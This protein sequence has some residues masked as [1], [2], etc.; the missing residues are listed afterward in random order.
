MNHF[1]YQ[2]KRVKLKELSELWKLPIAMICAIFYRIKHNDLWIICEDPNEARDNGYWFFKYLRKEHP[3]QDCVYAISSKSPD[4]N[5]IR[6]LGNWVEFG[7]LKH[8]ILYLA[9]TKKISSQKA[10]NPNAAIFY[11]LEV[12]GFLKDNRIFLQHG[13]IINDLKWLYYDVTKMHRFICGAYP[14]YEFIRNNFGYPLENVVYTGICRFDGLHDNIS[15]DTRIILIMP[16][17]REWIADEDSRLLQYEGT[18][19]IA[20]TNYFINW[21]SFLKDQ[22]LERIA[23]QYNCRFIFFPHRNMQK[24]MDL[25]PRSTYYLEVADARQYDVQN[26]M[27]KA[28]L[29]ITDYSS[30]FM[31]ML[32][33]KKPVIFYQFDYDRFRMG[34]YGEGYFSYTQNPF[35]KSYI[36]KKDVLV[37]LEQKISE[38]FAVSNEYLLAHKEYF[39]L[40]DNSNCKRVY[41]VVKES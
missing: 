17:W 40:Y 38:G 32:Y 6:E 16:T 2:L 29:M 7:S 19:D 35:A 11:F 4:I 10:G 39:R 21:I 26:L 15:D 31:D 12:Y 30:V 36:T 28:S 3:E 5:K 33:M 14:E 27:K 23:N 18:K 9:S 25:F 8:W 34:Q 13:V 24:Y 37:A 1:L 20:K 22:E 41:L